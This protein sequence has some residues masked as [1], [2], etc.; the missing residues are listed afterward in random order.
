MD[1]KEDPSNL[2][3]IADVAGTRADQGR[4]AYGHDLCEAGASEFAGG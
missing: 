1:V 4:R 3:C 2:T